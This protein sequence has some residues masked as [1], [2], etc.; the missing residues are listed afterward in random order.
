MMPTDAIQNEV[1]VERVVDVMQGGRAGGEEG[2]IG[3]WQVE[4]SC[5]GTM[6]I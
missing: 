3:C 5:R 2:R 6:T 1:E 4:G